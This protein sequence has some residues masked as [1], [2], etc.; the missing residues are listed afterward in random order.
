MDKYD[1]DPIVN[2]YKKE[3]EER[4]LA[5]ERAKN[6]EEQKKKSRQESQK[7]IEEKKR[8]TEKTA[9]RLER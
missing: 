1:D 5:A 7:A 9:T 4:R 2:A 8:Q 3:L 6:L